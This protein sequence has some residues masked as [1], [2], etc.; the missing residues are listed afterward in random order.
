[1]QTIQQN[2]VV[3]QL[4]AQ[5]TDIKDRIKTKGLSQTAF[6]ELTTSAKTL[7]TKLDELLSKKGLLTQSDINDAYALIQDEK[8]KELEAMNKK[9]MRKTLAYIGIGIL[10][11]GTLVYLRKK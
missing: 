10:V 9:A 5:I 11:V 7:Q 1:M 6:E 3:D 8:R 2:S 4:V